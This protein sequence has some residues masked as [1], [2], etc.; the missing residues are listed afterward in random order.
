MATTGGSPSLEAQLVRGITV[1]VLAGFL[2]A[3]TAYWFLMIG[4]YW[5]V[6]PY[7]VGGNVGYMS[8]NAVRGFAAFGT[9]MALILAPLAYGLFLRG[10]ALIAAI[11]AEW[12]GAFLGGL[13]GALMAGPMLAWLT[14]SIGLLCMSW[15]VGNLKPADPSS[16]SNLP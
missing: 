6:P 5:G 12:A 9:P 15:L 11:A 16:V 13:V 3:P 2:A 14:A 1:T 8:E 7:N 4:Q 10:R